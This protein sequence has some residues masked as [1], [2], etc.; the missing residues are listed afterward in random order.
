MT[1]ERRKWIVFVAV[2]VASG[3]ADQLSKAWA[4]AALP[5]RP[6]G[7]SVPDDMIEGRCIGEPVSVISGFWDWQLSMN[8]G[9]AFGL[10]SGQTGARIFLSIIAVV[11]VAAMV[12]ML[13]RAKPEQRAAAWALGLVVGGALGNLFDRT[14]FGVV[15]DFV[16]WRYGAHRWPTFN[17][18]DVFLVLGVVLMMI[19]MREPR[20]ETA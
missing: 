9:S 1:A 6:E 8:P 10:F 2:A 4:R 7:C 18:A 17:G 3:L 13:R 11:A 5:V 20:K 12:Y 16:V 14:V 19:A 15:T